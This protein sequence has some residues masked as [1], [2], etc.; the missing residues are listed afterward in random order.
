LKYN[1]SVFG[2]I[3][4]FVAKAKNTGSNPFAVVVFLVV[5]ISS[6]NTVVDTIS[7]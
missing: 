1:F 2:L 5:V 6:G 7:C 4:S 3:L